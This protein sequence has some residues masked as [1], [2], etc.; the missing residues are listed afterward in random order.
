MDANSVEITV[1]GQGQVAYPAE[2]CRVSL[3]V[4]SDGRSAE[5]AAEPA[6]RIV[7]ELTGLIDPL[8]NS[9]VG[10]IDAWTLDQVR[11]FRYRPT[12]I[13]GEQLP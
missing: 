12:N 10:P 2:R 6:H 1:V 7:R 13:D 11:H 9:D 5:A 8:Y 3:V 4:K